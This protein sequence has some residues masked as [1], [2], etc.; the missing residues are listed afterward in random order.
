MSEK[1]SEAKPNLPTGK[2]GKGFLLLVA[3]ALG[4]G[5][6]GAA[7]LSFYPQLF[8][9]TRGRA[10]RGGERARARF[11][12]MQEQIREMGKLQDQTSSGRYN[13]KRRPRPSKNKQSKPISDPEEEPLQC[14]G[15]PGTPLSFDSPPELCGGGGET[16]GE[17]DEETVKETV[18]E[19]VEETAGETDGDAKLGEEKEGGGEME[20]ERVR[21]EIGGD[22]DARVVGVIR[23]AVGRD[24]PE[25]KLTKIQSATHT[26]F[27]LH[28][29]G[30]PI[31]GYVD[32][33]I[34][35]MDTDGIV[36][37]EY[38]GAI[39]CDDGKSI[40][41][42]SR[43][44]FLPVP[45]P[46]AQSFTL[47]LMSFNI[48]NTNLFEPRLPLLQEAMKGIDIIGVQEVRA[49]VQIHSESDG[50]GSTRYQSKALSDLRPDMEYV[51]APAQ[52]F[53]E[54][55]QG[56]IHTVH[57]GLAIMS[58]HPILS[59]R[60]IPLS[61]DRTDGS[62][63]HQRVCLHTEIAVPTAI[64]KLHF[65]TTHLSLSERARKRTLHEITAYIDDLEG[66]VILTGDFNN[67]IGSS[68]HPLDPS[69]ILSTAGLKDAFLAAGYGGPGQRG[70][71]FPSW[72]PIKRIDGVYT[73]GLI[74]NEFEHRGTEPV[75]CDAGLPR[76]GECCRGENGFLFP[77]DH[78]FPI[79][80][81]TIPA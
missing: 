30:E 31:V 27:K 73:R 44:G 77:S 5:V 62:D 28:T 6:A 43:F 9:D 26:E 35:V 53:P 55:A 3:L 18:E 72:K 81:V 23:A 15:P 54:R 67:P 64:G 8:A 58:A 1:R 66:P 34:S 56:P 29:W 68:D 74:I 50:H 24:L 17:S 14:S 41:I 39:D 45:I 47:K 7:L 61:I 12:L 22:I 70:N 25:M 65:L 49:K 11:E 36:K 80:H 57:E 59:R 75:K 71:T 20:R 78:T 79:A 21:L 33:H 52:M 63:Y 38:I 42:V 37:E 10:I 60:A 16:D 69:E 19:T 4:V 13:P 40:S 76:A 46:T 51:Y 2:G 32:A 48:W